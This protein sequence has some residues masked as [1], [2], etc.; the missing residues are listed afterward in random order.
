MSNAALA[1][2]EIRTPLRDLR[3]D[4]LLTQAQLAQKAKLSLRTIYSIE[5]GMPCR[6][7]TKR[8]LLKALGVPFERNREVF[9]RVEVKVSQSA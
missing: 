6:M 5:K 1:T 7:D 2:R 9:P 3:Q 4:Q 8:K